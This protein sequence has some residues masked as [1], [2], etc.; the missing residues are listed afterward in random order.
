MKNLQRTVIASSLL[1]LTASAVAAETSPVTGNVA[2]TTNY[3]WRGVTQ[4]AEEMAIQGGFDYVHTGG[5]KGHEGPTGFYMGIWGSNV[6]FGALEDS[7]VTNLDERAHMELDLYGGYKFKG[8]GV[9]WDVG[10]LHYAYPG[11]A[12]AA[13]YDWTEVYVGG[14]YGPF[15]A[16]YSYTSDY[17]SSLT[18]EGASYLEA[19][20][21]FD[22]G[23]GFGLAL[24]AGKSGDDG[25]KQA[26]GDTYIDYKVAISKAFGG[27]NFALG[28]TDTDFSGAQE[29]KKGAFANDGQWMLTASKSM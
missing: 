15:S 26:W 18:D 25:I 17:T 4:T 24:H 27:V 2:L 20:L 10:V 5:A 11:A 3:V 6:N 19:N 1:V 23:Q 9:D 8:A 28:F 7:N 13:D 14:G 22:L 16:K 29:I 21:N 12:G